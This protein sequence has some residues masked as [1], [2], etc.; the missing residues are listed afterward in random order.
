MEAGG[1]RE[2]TDIAQNGNTKVVGH[3][4]VLGEK[5]HEHAVKTKLPPSPTYN[6]R[7]IPHLE[8]TQNNNVGN[9]R[10]TKHQ[11]QHKT[12]LRSPVKVAAGI[13]DTLH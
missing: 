6:M 8:G 12:K 7:D 2:A 13:Y 10:R 11:T 3:F 1:H 5:W 4:P 9:I